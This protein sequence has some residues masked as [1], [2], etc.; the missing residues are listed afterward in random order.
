MKHRFLLHS[1]SHRV[2][3]IDIT[4]EGLTPGALARIEQ[5]RVPILRFRTWELAS[6]YF[7]SHG[8]DRKLLED[9]A[10]WLKKCGT[11][12]LTIL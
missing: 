8:A 6:D 12:T 7:I 3:A 1:L 10:S 5:E 11:A 4:D 9:A 2:I